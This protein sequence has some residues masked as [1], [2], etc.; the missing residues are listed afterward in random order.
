MNLPLVLKEEARIQILLHR[1][2]LKTLAITARHTGKKI[3]G[4][5]E[6]ERAREIGEVDKG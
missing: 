3:T 5:S 1:R 4:A 6:A 2:T